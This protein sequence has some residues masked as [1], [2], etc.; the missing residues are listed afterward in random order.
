[1]R[2][3]LALGLA[4]V[5]AACSG[6]GSNGPSVPSLPWGEFRHD[7]T[8][9]AVGGFI[10]NNDGNVTMLASFPSSTGAT[11]TSSTPT[12]DHNNNIIFG[13]SKGIMAVGSD[14][15]QRFVFEGFMASAVTPSESQSPC[16]AC[17]P[18]SDPNCHP[19]GS[20][21]ASPTVTPGNEVVFGN[22]GSDGNAPYFFAIQERPDTPDCL[23]AVPMPKGTHSSVI[24]QIYS[25]DLS[26]QTIYAASD[27]GVLRAVN[28]DGSTRWS[29]T[30]GRGPITSTPALDGTGNIYV[31]TPD[32]MLLA[33][34]SGGR[35]LTSG[36]PFST[37]V[38]PVTTPYQP[39]PGLGPSAYVIGADGTLFQGKPQGWQF[40]ANDP[41]LVGSPA[42]QTQT[43]S[44]MATPVTDTIIYAVDTAGTAYGVRSQ[45]GEI[46]Q[47]Q[48]CSEDVN[49]ECRTDSCNPTGAIPPVDTCSPSTPHRCE[50]TGQT[51]T[52]DTCV[53]DNH[54]N[55]LVSNGPVSFAAEPVSISGSPSLSADPFIVVGAMDG[56]VCARTLANLVPGQTLSP[57]AGP[58]RGDHCSIT[59]VQTCSG[60]GACPPGEQC[61]QANQCNATGQPCRIDSDC[62]QT[63]AGELQYCV[64]VGCIPLS[65]PSSGPVLSSPVIGIDNTIYATTAKGLYVIK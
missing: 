30:T 17:S 52:E 61:V 26:L 24:A 49:I 18:G 20:V 4:V 50:I 65:V 48:R 22:D 41:P 13:T 59:T 36:F 33:F 9:A 56:Q 29:V 27:D 64:Y 31:T 42:L 3:R 43:F 37:G 55:C 1:M 57:P 16:A 32:G 53:V 60:N 44:F 51:C 54:G 21:S 11:A 58:W 47:Q 14:G 25:L 10:N 28:S 15:T 23:W 6:G 39:S 46:L 34:D 7:D 45:T 12:I 19:V 40:R 35:P 63:P 38:P 2:F 62:T 8:N 5:L